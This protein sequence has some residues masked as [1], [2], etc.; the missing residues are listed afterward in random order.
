LLLG[1]SSISESK[2]KWG[3]ELVLLGVLVHPS[4]DGVQFHLSDEK[5]A[6][7]TADIRAALQCNH[8]SS[9][10]AVKLGGR[11]MFSTQRLFHRVGR[12]P[13]KP[14]YAQKASRNGRMRPRLRSALQW[15]L[16]VL[17]QRVTELREWE[18]T[19]VPACHMFLDAASTPA[20][21]AAILFID[22]RRLYTDAAPSEA[23]LRQF[24]SRNDNQITGLEIFAIALGLSTFQ[25]DVAGR[26]LVLYSDNK[27]VP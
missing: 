26:V 19:I 6:K 27:G 8:L 3:K 10:Q 16:S 4:A 23:M 2:L 20:R 25:A 22:G 1:A 9:G 5:A 18:Q 13:I 21:C 11:L 15:W 14:I 12:A 7:Y 24:Q 17:Q